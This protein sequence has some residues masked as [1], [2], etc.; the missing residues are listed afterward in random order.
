MIFFYSGKA[1]VKYQ[2]IF[3]FQYFQLNY[4]FHETDYLQA[5]TVVRYNS[6]HIKQFMQ[7]QMIFQP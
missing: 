1:I 5:N 7:N 4:G 3:I 6:V 2:D